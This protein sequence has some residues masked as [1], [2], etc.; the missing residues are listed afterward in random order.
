MNAR[1]DIKISRN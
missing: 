1:T